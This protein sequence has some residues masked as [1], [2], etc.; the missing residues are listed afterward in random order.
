MAQVIARVSENIS[1]EQLTT[2]LD[3]VNAE[4]TQT[5]SALRGS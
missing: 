1:A 2:M 3:E 4:F 5:V